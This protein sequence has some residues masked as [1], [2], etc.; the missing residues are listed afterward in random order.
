MKLIEELREIL[1]TTCKEIILNDDIADEI[2]YKTKNELV[3]Q[4]DILAERYI[5]SEIK[6]IRPNDLFIGEEEN[7]NVLT[8]AKTWIID[9]ID[10]SLNFSRGISQFG[11]QV[12]LYENSKAK[13]C[14]V[15]LPVTNDFYY[16]VSDKGSFLNNKRI[17]L[18]NEL[19]LSKSIVSFGDFSSSQSESRPLQVSMISKLMNNSMKVRIYGA[20]SSDFAYVSSGKT[21]V[22]ITFTKRIWELAAGV[23]LAKEAGCIIHE[24][25]MEG[26]TGLIIASSQ[27]ILDEVIDLVF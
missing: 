26:V 7:N 3:T 21:Q 14:A 4:K 27:V 8:D 13:L 19:S 5:I 10:G 9:P 2:T 1:I 23:L 17:H 18:D 15:Y 6:R 16:A 24:F 20:S 12:A 22:Y 25:N 11:I